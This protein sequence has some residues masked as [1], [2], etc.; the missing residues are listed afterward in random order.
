[1]SLL[2]FPS[3]VPWMI[4]AWIVAYVFLVMTNRPAWAPLAISVLVL[5]IRTVPRTPAMLLL[6]GVFVIIVAIRFRTRREPMRFV[7]WKLLMLGLLPRRLR[8]R[9]EQESKR[10]IPPQLSPALRN[11]HG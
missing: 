2:V 4:A 6:G 3:V 8:A 11:R 9:L 1:V 5:V 7:R 10:R